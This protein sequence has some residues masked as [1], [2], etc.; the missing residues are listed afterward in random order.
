MTKCVCVGG[1]R[2]GV[3]PNM[4]LSQEIQPS[5]TSAEEI[6]KAGRSFQSLIILVI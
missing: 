6:I 4:Y 3:R 1:G 5:D 2:G